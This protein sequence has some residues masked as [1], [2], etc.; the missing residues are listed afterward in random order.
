MV[1]EVMEVMMMMMM[2][3]MMTMTMMLITILGGEDECVKEGLE[4]LDG[5]N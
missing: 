5:E 4:E 1:M 2:M 3:M